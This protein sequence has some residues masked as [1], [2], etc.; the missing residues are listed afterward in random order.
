[1]LFLI[2]LVIGAILGVLVMGAIKSGEMMEALHTAARMREE[3]EKFSRKG[4]K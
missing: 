2:G 4:E 1:M 3:L